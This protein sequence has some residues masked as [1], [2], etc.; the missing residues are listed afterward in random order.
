MLTNLRRFSL[1][2]LLLL[3]LV[4]AAQDA[5][6]PPCSERPLVVLLP[7]V[8]SILWCIEK[9]IDLGS[10]LVSTAITFAEDGTL[11]ATS[12]QRGE[13]FAFGD[14]N[15]DDLP[16]QPR[17]LADGLRLPNGLAYADG[18]LY[19]AGDGLI[20]AYEDEEIRVLADDLPGGRGFF[21]SGIAIHE[22]ALYIG[23]PAPC[24][25]CVPDDP[26]RGTVLR[27]TLDGTGREV[28]ARGLRYPAGLAIH[29]GA[30][31]V[32][33]SASDTL[34][35]QGFY[36]ELNVIDLARDDVPHFGWP[37]C[38][39]L[40]NEAHLPGDFDCAEATA[41][42][43][44]FATGSI[45]LDLLSYQSRTFPFL[46]GDLIFVLGGS[47]YQN[48]I[49]G[50]QVGFFDVQADGTRI[51]ESILPQDRVVAGVDRLPYDAE[52]GYDSR[53]VEVLN[54]RGAGTWPHRIF[55]VAESPEG[56]LYISVGGGIIYVLR[57]GDSDPCEFRECEG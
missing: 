46:T 18:V 40:E 22:E 16:D 6:L 31:W 28:V 27:M 23:V 1:L 17:V 33:D 55:S 37:Y 50:Y 10:E 56:Y 34:E 9:P 15:G 26:L 45:P 39:G 35:H 24:D 53:A 8:E 13:L 41:P 52:R 54:R 49:R 29:D 38:I 25:D 48:P 20:Y 36:D 2:M 11:Y 30:L 47:L 7:R 12:P 51:V 5:N 3:A 19:I 57:P 43:I 4:T 14:S 32:T 21:T 42:S 44:T